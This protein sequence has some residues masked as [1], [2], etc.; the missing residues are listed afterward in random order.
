MRTEPLRAAAIEAWDREG[1]M[2]ERRRLT[3]LERL[4]VWNRTGGHCALCE[5]RL[6]FLSAWH[7]DHIEAFIR[8]GVT[9][10]SGLQP[11]CGPCNLKKG[12]KR[13][14]RSL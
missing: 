8:T 3:N 2:A 12:L 6:P 13:D 14:E 9:F 10:L 5:R 11:L 4:I 1:S 7:A